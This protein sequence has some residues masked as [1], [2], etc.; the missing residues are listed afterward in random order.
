M[1]V[2]R[3]FNSTNRGLFVV[4]SQLALGGYWLALFVG[5]HLPVG[6]PFLP[7]HVVDKFVHASTFVIL[8][9]LLAT[10]W[11]LSAGF[12]TTRHLIWT[13]IA[14]STYAALDEITQ[15]IVGRECSF[16][17]WIADI[18]GAALGLT[19]FVWLRRR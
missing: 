17:D 3:M 15:P 19:V 4:A 6:T 10:T 1:N 18:T 13:W 9:T 12:L 8:G 16:W 14:V 5:T 7:G 11:Q 2:S